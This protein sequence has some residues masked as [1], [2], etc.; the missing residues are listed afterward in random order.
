MNRFTGMF[1][2]AVTGALAYLVMTNSISLIDAASRAGITLLAV[3]VTQR[4]ARR[5]MALLADSLERQPAAR[6]GRRKTDAQSEI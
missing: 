1:G 2:L 5:L 3:I 6:Y 4:L